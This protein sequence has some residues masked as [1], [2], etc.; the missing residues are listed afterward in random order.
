MGK[1]DQWENDGAFQLVYLGTCIG[2][3][4]LWRFPYVMYVNGGG[5]FFIPYLIC[6]FVLG[7]PLTYLEFSVGQYFREPVMDI[8]KKTS[9]KWQGLVFL[10]ILIIF[11]Y[12]IYLVMIIVY[13]FLYL[14]V[15]FKPILPWDDKNYY[16]FKDNKDLLFRTKDFFYNKILDSVENKGEIGSINY[17]VLVS[18]IVTWI[19]IYC[20]LK[21]GIKNTGKIAKYTVIAP[22]IFMI[23]LFVRVL[24]LDGSLDGI[25][26]LIYPDF[27]KLFTIRIWKDGMTMGIFQF[28]VGTC[29]TLSLATF[30]KKTDEVRITSRKLV[31]TI[32]VTSMFS[33]LV[34]FAYLGYFVKLT[35]STFE[36]LPISGADQAFVTYPAI[37]TEMTF[38]NLWLAIFC[39]T[40]ILFGIDSTFGPVEILCYFVKDSLKLDE[41]KFNGGKFSAIL[42]CS[43]LAIAGSIQCTQGGFYI[44]TLQDTYNFAINPMISNILHIVL[45]IYKTNHESLFNQL[46]ECNKDKIDHIS[47]F[48]LKYVD[49]W[50]LII[51][52]IFGVYETA[53][54]DD[55]EFPFGMKIAGYMLISIQLIPLIYYF[56]RYRNDTDNY[57]IYNIDQKAPLQTEEENSTTNLLQNGIEMKKSGD[58]NQYKFPK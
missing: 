16:E 29:I 44:M 54:T 30:R 33:S 41:T 24:F 18:F 56:V 11:G 22:F 51:Q 47:I 13:A 53:F 5:A 20:C 25:Y 12:T 14:V 58:W 28:C 45:F 27:S 3:A 52:A 21:N 15:C 9:K 26:Y 42:V 4:M 17:K 40:L 10:C 46:T 36:D 32:A 31:C 19:L 23:Q 34:V 6:L 55:Y 7:I 49:I 48:M 37:F 1:R 57:E 38:G 8:F 39:I 50:L 35:D 2:Y 43:V